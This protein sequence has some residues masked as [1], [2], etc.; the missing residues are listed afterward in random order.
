MSEVLLLSGPMSAVQGTA[1]ATDR[2]AALRGICGLESIRQQQ[3]GR[4]AGR[5]RR[6]PAF[7]HYLQHRRLTALAG[8]REGALLEMLSGSCLLY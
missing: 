4:M 2:L 6:L 5:V 8:A 7:E 1:T 3:V